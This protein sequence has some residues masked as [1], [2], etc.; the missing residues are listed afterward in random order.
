RR[1]KLLSLGYGSFH[2]ERGRCENKLGTEQQKHFPALERHRFWHDEEQAVAMRGGHECKRNAGVAGSRLDK[3]ALS[4]LDLSRMLQRLDHGD[5]N[6]VLH[7]RNRVEKF[8]FRKQV[9][10][11]AIHPRELFEA[12]EGRISDRLGDA[13]V[14]PAPAGGAAVLFTW[15]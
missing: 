6:T 1:D 8:K 15:G 14:N 12:H 9:G 2:A 13:V 10:S 3:N 5:A 7:T 11:N 4:G